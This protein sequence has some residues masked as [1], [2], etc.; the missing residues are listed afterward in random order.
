MIDCFFNLRYKGNRWFDGL[1]VM[2]HPNAV[3]VMSSRPVIRMDMKDI[4]TETFDQFRMKLAVR[5]ADLYLSF[6]Y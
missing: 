1:K 2:E 3:G 4:P 6:G 5:I